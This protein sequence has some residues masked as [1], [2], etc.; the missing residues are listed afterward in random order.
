MRAISKGLRQGKKHRHAYNSHVAQ[1]RLEKYYTRKK[2]LRKYKNACRF[3]AKSQNADGSQSKGSSLLDEVLKRDAEY[4]RRLS[5]S[6]GIGASSQDP[7]EENQEAALPKK[8][9]RRNADAV[10]TEVIGS[11]REAGHA[12][13]P[14]PRTKRRRKSRPDATQEAEV[15]AVVAPVRRQAGSN[16]VEGPSKQLTKQKAQGKNASVPNRFSRDLKEFR[17]RKDAEAQE[18]QRR[19]D[20]E[21]SRKRR[22]KE[23][24]K[25]RA[26][27]GQILS[28]KTARGQPKMAGILEAVTAKLVAE[29]RQTGKR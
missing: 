23:T 2:A 10:A 1:D 25:G 7:V 17:E 8:R 28:Q 24:A 6:F 5:L 11:E 15:T 26:L 18:W 20:E 21:L 4:E 13:E 14:V 16:G 22:R 19:R 27:K 9:R 3:E 12:S 29:Q